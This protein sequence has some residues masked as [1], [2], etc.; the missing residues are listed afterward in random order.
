MGEAYCARDSKSAA[1]LLSRSYPL[2]CK[3]SRKARAPSARSQ[4]PC[5][6]ESFQHR[7]HIRCSK[8]LAQTRAGD[9]L[10]EGPTLADRILP[11]LSALEEALTIAKQIVG[12]AGVC[13]RAAASYIATSSPRISRSSADRHGQAARLRIGEGARSTPGERRH[14]KFANVHTRGNA[15]GTDP[16][17]G[18]LHVPGAV[19]GRATDGRLTFGRSVRACSRCS[20]ARWAFSGREP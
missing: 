10:V 16:G 20:R 18:G 2:R 12:G 8:I 7:F 11:A 9:G 4:G 13:A 15:G 14:S 3:R 5:V 1:L 17:Y 6:V 19:Q